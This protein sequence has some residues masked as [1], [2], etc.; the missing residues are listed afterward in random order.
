MLARAGATRSS[1]GC[2]LVRCNRPAIIFATLRITQGET[3]DIA[4]R[5][6]RPKRSNVM[7]DS[8]VSDA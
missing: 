4:A 7:S 6:A 3:C 5:F 8:A 1:V 2:P